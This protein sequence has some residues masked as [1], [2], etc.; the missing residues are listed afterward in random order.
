MERLKLKGCASGHH[1]LLRAL[2]KYQLFDI[3]EDHL[4]VH[5]KVQLAGELEAIPR[6]MEDKVSSKDMEYL[7]WEQG[8]VIPT[9]AHNSWPHLFVFRPRWRE[10]FSVLP[11]TSGVF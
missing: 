7:Q 6:L 9:H 5:E 10:E 8:S 11:A 3:R 1:R 2:T 4:S